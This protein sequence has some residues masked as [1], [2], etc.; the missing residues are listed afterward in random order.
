MGHIDYDAIAS[1]DALIDVSDAAARATMIR[2]RER[3]AQL[4]ASL[5]QRLVMD[6]LHHKPALAFYHRR[7]P[8]LHVFPE[9]GVGLGLH[10]AVPLRTAE[11]P[12]LSTDPLAG[13]LKDALAHAARRR[14]VL[15]LEATLRS[16]SRVDDLL[17]LLQQRIDLLPR[18]H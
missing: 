5:E 10:V 7:E 8:L 14:N 6:G 2:L 9:P 1:L 18:M 12:L 11:L 3:L 17:P 13:W 4:D 16:A 15:W